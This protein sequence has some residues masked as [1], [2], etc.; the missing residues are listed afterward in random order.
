MPHHIPRH[1]RLAQYRLLPLTHDTHSIF[2]VRD[3]V[4][5][6]HDRLTGVLANGIVLRDPGVT[7]GVVVAPL[8][9]IE[10]NSTIVERGNRE[11]FLEIHALVAGVGVT[12]IIVW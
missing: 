10:V 12:A 11:V 4:F 1:A 7:P 9:G 5:F 8:V 2:S 3:S 6:Q